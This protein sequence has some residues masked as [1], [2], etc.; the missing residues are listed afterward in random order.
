MVSLEGVLSRVLVARKDDGLEL[1]ASGLD[2]KG[3]TMDT[4]RWVGS[5]NGGA[6]A[7]AARR[8]GAAAAR[9]FAP[10]AADA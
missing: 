7:A 1:D 4:L 2:G 9:D 5:D 10:S 6:A 8:S 3:T